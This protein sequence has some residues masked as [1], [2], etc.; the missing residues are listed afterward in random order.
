M[1]LTLK[2][3]E[4]RGVYGDAGAVIEPN[5][6]NASNATNA[7]NATKTTN[8]AKITNVTNAGVKSRLLMH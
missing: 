8:V 7:T 4:K 3:G 1:H 5:F 6:S 2:E